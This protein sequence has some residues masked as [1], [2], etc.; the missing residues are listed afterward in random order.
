MSRLDKA[1]SRLGSAVN[2]LESRVGDRLRQ[3][4]S[5]APD[6]MISQE[7]LKLRAENSRLNEELSQALN[8]EAAVRAASAGAA[9][10]VD[11]AIS[12]ISRVLAAESA[13]G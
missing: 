13:E 5:G 8:E 4:A 12:R 7:L 6:P 2:T 3:A 11:R 9:Q 1:L 10:R